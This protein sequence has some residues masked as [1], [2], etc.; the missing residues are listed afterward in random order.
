MGNKHCE[1]CALKLFQPLVKV[2]VIINVL[3]EVSNIIDLYAEFSIKYCHLHFRSDSLIRS[4][5]FKK[6]KTDDL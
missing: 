3:P 4:D 2:L 6:K 5:S 1:E